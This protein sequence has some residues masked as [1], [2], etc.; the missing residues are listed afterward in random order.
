MLGFAL[1]KAIVRVPNS[2][3]LS[4]PVL[5][6]LF[7]V[8]EGR[9]ERLWTRDVETKVPVDPVLGPLTLVTVSDETIE[10]DV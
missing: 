3:L 2:E 1:E 10:A 9:P 4:E 7:S 5:L 8:T 6:P